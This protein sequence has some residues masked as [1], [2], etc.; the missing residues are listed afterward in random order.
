MTYI[1]IIGSVSV[2]KTSFVRLFMKYIQEGKTQS[3]KGGVKCSLVST[4]F[5]GESILDPLSGVKET[6][7]IHPN[8]LVFQ[9][10]ESKQNHTLFAPGG[11]Q[12]RAVVKMGVI[13]ISKISKEIITLFSCI[14]DLDKQLKFFSDVNFFPNEIFVA[15]NKYDLIQA[16]DKDAYVEEMKRKIETFFAGRKKKVLDYI[17]TVADPINGW[18]DYNN[19]AAKLILDICLGRYQKKK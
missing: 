17:I 14:E 3:V 4:D 11:D 18:E 13:T 1:G 12:G 16:E 6:K 5:S 19:N 10:D 7:T 15:L 9:E 2:G 8:R